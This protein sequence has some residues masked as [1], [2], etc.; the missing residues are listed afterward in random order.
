MPPAELPII[1]YFILSVF[2]IIS[3]PACLSSQRHNRLWQSS[4]FLSIV[5]LSCQAFYLGGTIR[6]L[7][8]DQRLVRAISHTNGNFFSLAKVAFQRLLLLLVL[9]YRR[10]R[11]DQNACPAA[12]APV[13]VH[14]HQQALRV[15][16]KGT[17][18]T[19]LNAGRIFALLTAH[20]KRH[21]PPLIHP[22]PGQGRRRLFLEGLDQV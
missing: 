7:D 22:Q 1:R 19:G 9:F 5:T 8:I 14:R 16:L 15:P 21:H 4:S 2:A 20:R 13:L 6:L 10:Q 17:G 11:T 18:K 3:P 12:D